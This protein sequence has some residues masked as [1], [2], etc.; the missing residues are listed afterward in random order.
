MESWEITLIFVF[1]RFDLGP[2]ALKSE[3]MMEESGIETTPPVS[4]APPVAAAAAASSAGPTAL[5][6]GK[7]P[8]RPLVKMAADVT[9]PLI[10]WC[11]VCPRCVQPFVP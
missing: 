11:S 9:R 4:P 7:T 6:T 1:V 2:S 5:S 8:H 3:T 10:H